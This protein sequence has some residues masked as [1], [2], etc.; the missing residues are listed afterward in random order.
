MSIWTQVLG[1]VRFD[2]QGSNK[3][4]IHNKGL[5]I[6][7]KA[8]SHAMPEGSEGPVEIKAI[9][10]ERGPTLLVT[11][12]LRD[13]YSNDVISVLAWLNESLE[14]IKNMDA[15]DR[16]FMHIRDGVVYCNVS[17]YIYGGLE[18]HIIKYSHEEK[19]F[20]QLA[21]FIYKK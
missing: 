9:Q 12:D 3:K 10:T 2:C 18:E 6:I 8:F 16:L 11:G 20:V 13:F 15:Y 1:V 5:P 19:R 14:L 21:T 4:I 17:C 7:L